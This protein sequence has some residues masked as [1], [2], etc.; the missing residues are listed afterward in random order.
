MNAWLFFNFMYF[1]MLFFTLSFF[2]KGEFTIVELLENILVSLLFSTMTVGLI[3]YL[4]KICLF[5]G[6]LL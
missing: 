5:L 3:Y 4:Y 2:K 6:E 1:V